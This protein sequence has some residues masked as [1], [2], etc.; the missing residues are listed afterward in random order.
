MT[1]ALYEHQ[2][3]LHVRKASNTPPEVNTSSPT[4]LNLLN[5]LMMNI[6]IFM[7][8]KDIRC[9]Y[10]MDHA[11]RELGE[12][13][14]E[15]TSATQDNDM[16]L[17]AIDHVELLVASGQALD[18]AELGDV[19]KACQMLWPSDAQ[20]LTQ[21]RITWIHRSMQ[22]GIL[23]GKPALLANHFQNFIVYCCMKLEELSQ[24]PQPD[25]ETSS[26]IIQAAYRWAR[27]GSGKDRP[28]I[29][30][31]NMAN[32]I[33]PF[34]QYIA[35]TIGDLEDFRDEIQI[36]LDIDKQEYGGSF[37]A[38]RA[39]E[40]GDYMEKCYELLASTTDH[41]EAKAAA[42]DLGYLFKIQS[43]AQQH[44]ILRRL[45]DTI[46]RHKQFLNMLKGNELEF[47][48]DEHDMKV[49]E[50]GYIK[51]EGQQQSRGDKAVEDAV[52]TS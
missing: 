40:C 33:T 5:S 4:P 9:L 23:A 27:R 30:V 39:A 1:N 41:D 19:T 48:S 26:C 17:E 32:P 24:P 37:V 46:R 38:L 51:D 20:I 25:S 28:E 3:T 10:A 8:T 15:G 11:L 45:E 34:A 22:Q 36:R 14:A 50:E 49:A 2:T 21:E 44:E 42:D 52:N 12:V 6:S 16:V 31:I 7:S 43:Q 13:R 47:D 29:P 18:D 35:A